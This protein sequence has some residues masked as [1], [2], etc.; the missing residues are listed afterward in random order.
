M[1]LEA[2]IGLLETLLAILADFR[3]GKLGPLVAEGRAERPG[4]AANPA[5]LA[6]PLN[7]RPGEGRRARVTPHPPASAR[8]ARGEGKMVKRLPTAR[9][10]ITIHMHSMVRWQPGGREAWPPGAQRVAACAAMAE[11]RHLSPVFSALVIGL[12]AIL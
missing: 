9:R 1:L 8:P 10:R 4:C 11:G 12:S 5:G 3:A 2:I 7:T 6:N